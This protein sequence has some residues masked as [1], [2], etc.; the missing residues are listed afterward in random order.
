MSQIVEGYITYT[1][2]INGRRLRPLSQQLFNIVPEDPLIELEN[3]I[4]THALGHMGTLTDDDMVEVE[5]DTSSIQFS[6]HSDTDVI[7]IPTLNTRIGEFNIQVVFDPYYP[8]ENGP[9][10]FNSQSVINNMRRRAASA[11]EG[12]LFA[13]IPNLPVRQDKLLTPNLNTVRNVG[14]ISVAKNT[15][16]PISQNEFEE[17]ENV[18]R[19]QGN[20][21]FVFKRPGIQSW[22]QISK[23]NPLS[24]EPMNASKV[25]KGKAKLVGGRKTRKQTKK[26]RKSR[27]SRKPRGRRV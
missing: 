24:R 21:R 23:T 14:N 6:I 19:L 22:F 13:P 1:L 27:K 18:V 3:A 7:E 16:D 4:T 5:L 26:S 15:I 8:D 25:E 20:N 10:N 17:G 2:R 11:R 12:M 9:I